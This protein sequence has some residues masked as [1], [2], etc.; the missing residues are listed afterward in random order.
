MAGKRRVGRNWWREYNCD[1]LRDADAAWQ[2]LRESGQAIGT[3]D[4]AG[5]DFT[6]GFNQLSDDEFRSIHPRP[7]LKAFLI[8]NKGMDKF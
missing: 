2:G 6:V 7:T 1:L 5:A 3:T 8:G 4:V